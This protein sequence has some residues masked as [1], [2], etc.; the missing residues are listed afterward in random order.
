MAPGHLHHDEKG[1]CLSEPQLCH[2]GC[3][4]VTPAVT[5]CHR[6]AGS[7]AAKS[8]LSSQTPSVQLP[9]LPLSSPMGLGKPRDFSKPQFSL[10]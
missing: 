1:L 5:G 3:G 8:G 7:A 10:Q 4:A 2:L 9:A 6:E